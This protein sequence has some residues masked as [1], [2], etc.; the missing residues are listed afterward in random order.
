MKKR[1]RRPMPFEVGNTYAGLSICREDA[2]FLLYIGGENYS[3]STQIHIR[4]VA[5]IK[6]LHKFL[7]KSLD[8][9]AQMDGTQDA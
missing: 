5:E 7:A 3:D 8:Y 1:K 6:R 9:L 4:K 2:P